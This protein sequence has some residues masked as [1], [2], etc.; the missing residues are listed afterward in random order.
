MGEYSRLEPKI[1]IPEKKITKLENP[2][3]QINRKYFFWDCRRDQTKKASLAEEN[4][5][6]QNLALANS[7]F[8]G[9]LGFAGSPGELGSRWLFLP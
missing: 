5:R 8:K 2:R 9:L 6:V 7:L 1:K 4:Y 3:Q